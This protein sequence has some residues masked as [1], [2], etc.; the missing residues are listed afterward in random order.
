[1]RV[2]HILG[3]MNVGG[4][5]AIVTA[6][7]GSL[8]SEIRILVGDV[9]TDEE[10]YVKLRSPSLP[11]THIRGLGRAVRPTDDLRALAGLVRQ[12][13]RLKPD[14]V[15]THTAKAGILG[16]VAASVTGVPIRVHTFHGHLL[17]GYFS[18]AGTQGIIAVERALALV[19]D[20]LIAVGDAVRED[21]LAAHIGKPDQYTVIPPGIDLA[22]PPPEKQEARTILGLPQAGPVVAYVAR[23]TAIKR[24]DRMIEVAKMLPAVTFLVAGDGPLRGDL[25]KKA[26][27]NVRFLGWRAD[28][29]NVYSSADVI[30]LTSD[31]EGMPVTLIEAALCGLPA[32]ATNA[33]STAEVVLDGKTGLIVSLDPSALATALEHF[34]SNENERRQMGLAAQAWAQSKFSVPKMAAAHMSLYESLVER[35]HSRYRRQI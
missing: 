25:Q 30:L 35:P 27:P 17:R 24:P 12:L 19:T 5:A 9:D 4:P 2:V 34:L 28:V 20:A 26:L 8:D 21:L 16:R 32:V 1:M 10:D 23:L 11:V 22:T 33:G 3:R 7:Q 18:H 13:S 15:H 29:E 6:L 14:I 31:N